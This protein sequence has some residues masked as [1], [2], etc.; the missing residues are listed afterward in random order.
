[1]SPTTT[2][3]WTYREFDIFN[4]ASWVF[5]IDD[6]AQ[7]LSN[8]CRFNGHIDFYSVAEHSIRVSE[9]LEAEG[10]FQNTVLLGLLHDAAE[11]YIGDVPGP[12]KKHLSLDGRPLEEVER[13]IELAIFDRFGAVFNEVEWAEV[14]MADK[15]AY[16]E[17]AHARPAPGKGWDPI[18]A[19]YNFLA[20]YRSLKS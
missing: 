5:D 18:L 4:P 6:I 7:A 20:R 17:E 16:K 1:M 13:E 11:A 2:L 15:A 10:A 8:Q 9:I 19:R 14:K 12:W 3:T